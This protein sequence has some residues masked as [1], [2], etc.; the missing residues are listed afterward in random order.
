MLR[1]Q[2][3]TKRDRRRND[4]ITMLLHLLRLGTDVTPAQ[5]ALSGIFAAAAV[6]RWV[7]S[8]I[9]NGKGVGMIVLQCCIP[10]QT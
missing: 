8:S 9:L 6:E 1:L 7:F 4:R 3:Y 5:P 10:A 2:Q